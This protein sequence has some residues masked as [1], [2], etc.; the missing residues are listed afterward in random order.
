MRC[1]R[2]CDWRGEGGFSLPEI[3]VSIIVL[4][5]IAGGTVSALVSSGKATAQERIR[6]QAQAIAQ[7]DQIRMRSMKVSDFGHRYTRTANVTQGANTFT[8]TSTAEFITESSGTSSCSEN[9]A[10]TEFIKIKSSVTWPT[11]GTRPPVVI[12]SLVAPP[13]GYTAP[14]RGN[15]QVSVQTST[16]TA[17]NGVSITGTGPTSFSG[18]TGTN[19]CVIFGNLPVGT[20]T[21][22][23]ALAGLVDANGNAATPQSVDIVG[24]ATKTLTLVY[25]TPGRITASFRVRNYAG[26]V[27]SSQQASGIVV[28]NTG[29]QTDRV[30]GTGSLAT[31]QQTTT[32]LFPFTSPYAVYAGRCAANNPGSGAGIVSATVAPGQNLTLSTAIQL[33]P[34]YLNVYMGTSASGTKSNGA[35]VRIEDLDCPGTVYNFTTNSSG[36]L[37]LPGLP[38][39]DYEVCVRG[40]SSS[41]TRRVLVAS[42]AVKSLTGTNLNVALGGGSTTALCT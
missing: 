29:M 12:E 10:S 34:L 28:F 18:T 19:G 1:A 2:R 27:V 13:T 37:P 21:V 36:Q 24:Q 32:T 30:F 8:V 11:I 35:Q 38:Y 39:S 26:T 31:T 42:T 33:F 40:P 9:T 15:L 20:Y 14:N 17:R 25:D 4:A 6:T 22:T 3:L 16:G 7:A 41:G 23:P 5:L